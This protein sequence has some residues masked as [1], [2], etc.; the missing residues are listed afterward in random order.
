MAER[1]TLVYITDVYLD[2]RTFQGTDTIVQGYG[3]MGIGSGIE[4]DTVVGESHL[5]HLVDQLSLDI[6]LVILQ[7][8]IRIAGTQ[9]GKV[10]I[11]R[12][13]PVDTW[14]THTEQIQVRTIYDENFHN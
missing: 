8:Y 6:A 14:L 1:L 7:L 11:K 2:D 5:L 3:G 9:L 4:H 12:A 13:V 10:V